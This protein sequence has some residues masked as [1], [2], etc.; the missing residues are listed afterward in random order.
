MKEKGTVY[1]IGAGP[2]D[3]GLLTIKGKEV[4]QRSDVVVYDYL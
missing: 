1:L 3:T 4:L 2:G